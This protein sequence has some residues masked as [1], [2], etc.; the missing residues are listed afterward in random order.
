MQV[1]REDKLL[2]GCQRYIGDT[3]GPAFVQGQPWSLDGVLPDTTALTPIVFILT[4]GADPTAMLQVTSRIDAASQPCCCRLQCES[5]MC[6][7]AEQWHVV[8]FQAFKASSPVLS[9][10]TLLK[11][12]MPCIAF[13]KNE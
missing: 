8:G 9:P 5:V 11:A 7:Q 2:L 12:N 10:C 3:L 4:S 6:F 1:M 13:L